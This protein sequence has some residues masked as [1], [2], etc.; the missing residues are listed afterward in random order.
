[1]FRAAG[2]APARRVYVPDGR[3]LE[4]TVDDLVAERFSSSAT[5]PHLFGDRLD[6]FEAD[7]RALLTDASPS[8]LFSVRLPDNTLD[9]WK[10]PVRSATESD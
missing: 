4:R 10:L 1:M 2:F 7:L 3:L 9:I 5:A 6:D 8:G